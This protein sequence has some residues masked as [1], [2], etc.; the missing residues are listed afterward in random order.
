[1]ASRWR[2]CRSSRPTCSTCRGSTPARS[3]CDAEP[4]DLAR[5]R[6]RRSRPS[7]RRR[8]PSTTPTL[9]LRL[10]ARPIRGRSA[11]LSGWRRS[12]ASCSTTR[13]ATRRRAPTIVVSAAR[14]QR[15]A[16]RSRWRD[17]GPGLRRTR[18]PR[19]SSRFY[20]GDAARGAGLGLAI[21]RELAERMDGRPARA[22]RRP[23]ARRSRSSCRSE[24]RARVSRRP[25]LAVGGARR[26]RRAATR[27]RATDTGRV[28]A[29]RRQVTTTRVQVVEGLGRQ[30]RLRPGGDLRAALAGRGD[31]SSSIFDGG[32]AC[33]T[34]RRGAARA[35]GFV[36]DGNG[37]IATNAHV[38]TTA[39]APSAKRASRSTSSS[40][41]AT[42]CA[43]EIVGD[44]PERRRRAAQGRPGGPRRSRRC[45]SAQSHAAAGRRAGGRDRQPVRRAPVAVDRRDLGARPHDRVAHRSSRSATRSRPT[46]RSTRGNS[47]GPLLDARGRVIGINAQISSTVRRRRGRRLRGPGR[48]RRRSLDELR[49]DGKVRLRA[50][51]ACQTLDALPAARRPARPAGRRAARWCRRSRTTAR[52][53]RRASRRA[54]DEISFQG[55]RTRRRRRDRHRG[56]RQPIRESRPRRA[57]SWPLSPGETVTLEVSATASSASSRDARRAAVTRARPRGCEARALAL[58][59]RVLPALGAHAG[60]AHVRSAAG[61]DVTFA[62]DAEAEAFLEASWPSA[63]RSRLL[64]G[65][66]RPGRAERRAEHVLVV[67][68]IDGTRPAMAGLEAACVAV[69]AA[70][71]RRR[72]A[73]DGRRRRRLRRR[74]QERRRAFVAER[75]EGCGAPRRSRS[76]RTRPRAAVLDLRL[77]RPPGARDGRG[78]R[79]ADRPLVGRRRR[80]RP[81]LGDAST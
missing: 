75:G 54:S 42:A 36:L 24:R 10:P 21:A 20:T 3:S 44:R 40:P 5:A 12:C 33:S 30:G 31:R 66:P 13:S 52:P 22:A 27:G 11:T 8:S 56:R 1:M 14:A 38:V 19:S 34:R 7:S 46:P 71:L 70:P 18:A 49:A 58:R 43:A 73:D 26:L 77:P 9:E 17:D 45:R 23:G 55:S 80:V 59:E 65:G 51:S 29:H 16:P 32:G 6:A 35:R 68:P 72:R 28:G 60:R 78:A 76:A 25:A 47:G 63:R 74:D 48:R 4:V 57:R 79:R 53:T 64:L 81:R 50:T 61:G 41:T 39:R 37:Y 2:A 69:A 62:I 15:H 67:D